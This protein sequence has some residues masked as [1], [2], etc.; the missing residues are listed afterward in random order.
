MSF[1][2]ILLSLLMGLSFVV[3]FIMS[4]KIKN[5]FMT[6]FATG[7]A[8][9]V[10][11]AVLFTDIIPELFELTS[12]YN[13]IWVAVLG[14]ILGIFA[15]VIMDIFVPH[16]HH[17]HKHNDESKKDHKDHLYHIG[18]LT[19]ISVLIH[20]VLE[21]IA[22][23][24]VGKASLKAALLM[25]GGI[26]LHN[27]PLGIEMS[28]FFKE[29]KDNHIKKYAALIL[30]GTIG[31]IIGLLLGDLCAITNIL[32]LSITCGMMLYI[33]LYELGIEAARNIKE[34][35]VIEGIL[36]GAIIFALI[37]L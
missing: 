30:S 2:V 32:V 29:Q 20:N 27:I 35:G 21:G 36:I 16:H 11:M 19:F 18:L 7:L 13:Q 26:A 22:F 8:F 17:D 28:Y 9:M 1:V 15:L 6:Y 31:A 12:N 24:L 25:A 5:K 3:G 37:L 10:I 34:K 4:K 23:Y 33:G 14:E